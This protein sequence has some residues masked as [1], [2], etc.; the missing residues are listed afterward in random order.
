[1]YTI[2]KSERKP[3]N[4]LA[5]EYLT[6][7]LC[8]SHSIHISYSFMLGCLFILLCFTTSL[9]WLFLQEKQRKFAQH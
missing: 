9:L 7:E 3:S 6:E 2:L 1:M 4:C 8:S 5:I